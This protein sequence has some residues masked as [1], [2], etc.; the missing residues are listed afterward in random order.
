M[1]R[2][3]DTQVLIDEA[4]LRAEV[5]RLR[6]ALRRLMAAGVK[7]IGQGR[8]MEGE[9]QREWTNAYNEGQAALN[10]DQGGTGHGTD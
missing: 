5:E 6:E 9:I 2:A 4:E 8:G 3:A 10:P 7:R 1:K